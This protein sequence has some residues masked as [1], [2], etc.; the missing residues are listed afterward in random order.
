MAW[1]DNAKTTAKLLTL[2]VSMLGF[3]LFV[4][5]P[6]YDAFCEITGLNGKT[7]ER[8]EAVPAAVDRERLVKVQFVA[9]NNENMPW[10]FRPGTVEMRVHPGE[11]ADT[12]FIARNP[13]GREMIAQAIP[14]LAPS[15]AAEY[16]HKTECFCFNQQTLAAGES[17]E[18]G[19]RFIVDP[20]LPR[21]VNTITLSYT[22]FDVTERM[23]K[24]TNNKKAD[25]PL[26][27]RE[28]KREG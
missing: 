19:L 25:A 12:V 11:P 16:F 6:L 3:A 5:P 27:E 21:G 15:K 18:L 22:L 26:T 9:T 4:M 14:S 1:S 17:A 28:S 8:Y 7:G 24:Q 10:E 2:A 20:D 13:S 23:A